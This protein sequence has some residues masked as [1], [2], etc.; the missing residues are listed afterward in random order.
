[1]ERTRYHEKKIEKRQKA[2]KKYKDSIEN[3]LSELSK[4]IREQ[5]ALCIKN[6]TCIQKLQKHLDVC[7]G[8]NGTGRYKCTKDFNGCKDI[9]NGRCGHY[10][11]IESASDEI[12]LMEGYVLEEN[13]K[14][15]SLEYDYK[16]ALA[17]KEDRLQE[18]Y[19]DYYS[20]DY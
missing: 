15:D 9:E 10:D 2:L 17:I 1:M 11:N 4:I 3:L 13:T 16:K 6:E 12:A 8:F 20:D 19:N 18:F 14:I 7:T 5:N